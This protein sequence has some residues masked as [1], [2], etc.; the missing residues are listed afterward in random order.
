[1]IGN[2]QEN[3][4]RISINFLSCSTIRV[5]SPQVVNSPLQQAFKQMLFNHLNGM[6]C[7]GFLLWVEDRL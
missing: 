2:C 1:M 4:F 6:L 5:F 7:E 3:R